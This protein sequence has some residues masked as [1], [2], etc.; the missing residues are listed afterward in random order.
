AA[1]MGM[2]RMLATSQLGFDLKLQF[3]DHLD[4]GLVFVQSLDSEVIKAFA[5]AGLAD[6]TRYAAAAEISAQ[7]QDAPR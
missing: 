2:A 7:P 5:D 6:P 4:S 3:F 1:G